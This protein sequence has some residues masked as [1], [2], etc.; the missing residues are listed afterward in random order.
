M[1]FLLTHH[2][3]QWMA[4]DC[5][6]Q[7]SSTLAPRAHVHLC[8]HVHDAQARLERHLGQRGASLR[9]IAGAAHGDPMEA[10]KHGYSWGAIRFHAGRWE[11]GWAPRIYVVERGEM[12]PDSTRYDLD[13]NGFSWETLDVSWMQ[14]APQRST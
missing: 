1:V 14:Y 3:V 10:K 6:T 5:A 7:L 12:R 2:P 8:G 9:Y 13:A 4:P 11:I